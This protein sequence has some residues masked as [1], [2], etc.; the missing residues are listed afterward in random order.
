MSTF[1]LVQIELSDIMKRKGV[2]IFQI[3]PSANRG[4]S[5]AAV[6]FLTNQYD[7]ANWR[8]FTHKG[9]QIQPWSH[10]RISMREAADYI[11]TLEEDDFHTRDALKVV[12]KAY[13]KFGMSGFLDNDDSNLYFSSVPTPISYESFEKLGGGQTTQHLKY[14]DRDPTKGA[15]RATLDGDVV[16]KIEI[17]YI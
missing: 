2:K 12:I 14:Y 3:I 6:G 5:N 11:Q 7:N 1:N 9:L 13:T 8:I 16:D 4:E 10:H 17:I 15:I